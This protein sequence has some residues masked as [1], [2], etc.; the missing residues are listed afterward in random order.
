MEGTIDKFSEFWRI[1]KHYLMVN[2]TEEPTYLLTRQH[3]GS[4]AAFCLAG[5]NTFLLRQKIIKN[6]I[7]VTQSNK[8][9]V[10]KGAAMGVGILYFLG[11]SVVWHIPSLF[12]E[13]GVRVYCSSENAMTSILFREYLKK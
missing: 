1:F 6:A 3:L 13:F 2:T 7:Y 4:Y 9:F 5:Y 10:V 12:A 11:L 8:S